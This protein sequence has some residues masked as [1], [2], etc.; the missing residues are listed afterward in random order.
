MRNERPFLNCVIVLGGSFNPVHSGHIA[1]AKAFVNLLKPTQLR[2][3][4]TGFSLYK[5]PIGVSDDDRIAMLSLACEAFNGITQWVIDTQEITRARGGVASFTVDTLT[6]LRREWGADTSLVFL[7]GADQLL[8]LHTWKNWRDL[9]ELAHFAVGARPSFDYHKINE[10]VASVWTTRSGTLA[11]LETTPYG[12]TYMWP[13]LLSEASSTA[14]RQGKRWDF[15]SPQV[16]TYIEQH[17]LY[18]T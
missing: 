4:P 7:M 6:T 15:V 11:S 13:H 5:Q 12:S 18:Q 2:M 9:F 17:H 16:R 3:I 14:I 10:E 1:L 8:L